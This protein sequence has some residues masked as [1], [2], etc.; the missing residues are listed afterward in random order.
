MKKKVLKNVPLLF[1]YSIAC[2]AV[3]L[4][5]FFVKNRYFLGIA[6][7]IVSLFLAF[8]ASKSWFLLIIFGFIFY[9][10]YSI[11]VFHYFDVGSTDS[12]YAAYNKTTISYQALQVLFIFI[13]CIGVP[14]VF[15]NSEKESATNALFASKNNYPVIG[16][17]CIAALLFI[18]LF[19]F[20][21]SSSGRIDATA[22]GEY[23]VIFLILGLFFCKDNKYLF[24]TLAAEGIA[25]CLIGFLG[26]SRAAGVQYLIVLF[27]FCIMPHVKRKWLIL[28]P[29]VLIIVVMKTIGSMR[30]NVSFGVS[31][32]Y[33]G[34]SELASGGF[35][36]DT[37]YSSYHTSIIFMRL[38]SELP[39]SY[40]IS[41][42]GQFFLSIFGGSLIK[43]SSLSSFSQSYYWNGGGGTLPHYFY[44]YLGYIGVFLIAIFTCVLLK[45]FYLKKQNDYSICFVIF[46]TTTVPRW[47]LYS[48]TTFFRGVLVFSLVYF[49]FHCLT[50]KEMSTNQVSRV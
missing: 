20:R 49:I 4:L 45:V 17:I 2:V 18:L 41:L 1:I 28:L 11:V 7:I 14:V 29:I 15:K 38:S 5:S 16:L 31:N 8:K 21:S 25:F 46:I 23:G 34:F 39:F 13:S 19:G 26:G 50:K 33:D 42:L 44:F 24:L 30:N 48:P 40:H 12:A 9:C 3:F 27:V 47:F 43:N 32:L 6:S 36:F 35:A 37:A 22:I 10:V